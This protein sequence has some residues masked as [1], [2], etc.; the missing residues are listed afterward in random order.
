MRKTDIKYTCFGSWLEMW[1]ADKRSV[2]NAMSRNMADDLKVG[3]DFSS[4]MIKKQLSEIESY[5]KG[6]NDTYDLFKTMSDEEV[7]RYC[8]YDLKKRGVIE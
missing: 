3:Y 5:E 1:E 4:H 2:L 6:I 8:F 7:E